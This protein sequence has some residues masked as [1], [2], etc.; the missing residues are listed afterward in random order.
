[1]NRARKLVAGVTLMELLVAAVIAGGITIATVRALGVAINTSKSIQNNRAEEQKRVVFEDTVTTW[2]R[3]AWL[4]P[5]T[6]EPISYFIAQVG[7]MS[8]G[9]TSQIVT[10]TT[11]TTTTTGT[12]AGA[13]AAATPTASGGGSPAPSDNPLSNS[14]NSDDL[15][16][17]AVGTAPPVQLFTSQDDWQTANQ[18]FGPQGGVAEVCLSLVPQQDPGNHTHGLYIRLQ[19]PADQDPTQGGFERLLSADVSSIGYQF[20]D[21]QNWD[22]TW[23]TRQLTPQQLPAAVRVT[24]RFEHDTQDHMFVVLLPYSNVNYNNPVENPPQ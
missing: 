2:I 24:Y 13:T 12:T 18:D 14:G 21:G 6:A 11:T 9:D 7:P 1:M 4:A 19:H 15:T 10:A 5:S 22:Q 20:Y 3:L 16:F 23:D 8:P 17:T